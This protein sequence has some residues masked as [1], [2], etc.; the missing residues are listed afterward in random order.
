MFSVARFFDFLSFKKMSEWDGVNIYNPKNVSASVGLPFGKRMLLLEISRHCSSVKE[1]CHS[2][3]FS[4]PNGL[5]PSEHSDAAL[6]LLKITCGFLV[7]LLL[8]CFSI[9]SASKESLPGSSSGSDV[10]PML[11]TSEDSS[12]SICFQLQ[13]S[14]HVLFCP[15]TCPCN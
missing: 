15:L 4:E 10:E 2:S 5:L 13:Q 8:C 11:W 9:S 3:V 12:H 6:Q 14:L 1:A 7:L